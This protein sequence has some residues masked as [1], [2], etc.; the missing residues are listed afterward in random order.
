MIVPLFARV[1]LER[2]MLKT[3][4]ILV[5]KAYEQRNAPTHGKVIAVG[6]TCD[7]N[8]K[9]LVGKNVLFGKFSGEWVKDGDREIYLVQEEDLIGVIED[10]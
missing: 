7:D 8:I 4:G 9:S 2:P 6:P 5:P 10:D 3:T 1:L